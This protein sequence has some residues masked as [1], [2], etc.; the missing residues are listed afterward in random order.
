MEN[1]PSTGKD[2]LKSVK[3]SI[4]PSLLLVLNIFFFGTFSI[5]IANSGEF[6]ISYLQITYLLLLPSLATLIFLQVLYIILRTPVR[7]Y[8]LTLILI[9][10][11]LTYIHSNILLWDYGI[12]DGT[13][14]DFTNDWRAW[15]DGAIWMLLLITGII[16]HQKIIEY[17][18][19]ISGLLI[20]IQFAGASVSY[21]QS[22]DDPLIIKQVQEFPD[23]L[24][25]FSKNGNVIHIILDAFQADIFEEL[26]SE[27]PTYSGL[28]SG[29]TFFRDA[30]TPSA[31]TYLSVSASLSGKVFLNDQ[32][33]SEYLEDTLRGENLYSFFDRHGYEIDV[34]TSL[35]WNKSNELFSSYFRIPAPYLTENQNL[36]TTLMVFDLSIFRQVP[37]FL[38][39][40]VYNSQTWLFSNNFTQNPA[41]RFEHYAHNAFLEDLSFRMSATNRPPVYKF[42]HLV[43]PHAPMVSDKTC[44]FP[45]QVLAY[46]RVNFTQQSLCTMRTVGNFLQNLKKNGIYDSSLILIH[47]DHGGGVPFTMRAHN[48]QITSSKDTKYKLWGA[49]LPLILVKPPNE[50][51]P[52]RISNSQVQLNDIPATV[53]S[54]LGLENNFQG[55]PMY[56]LQEENIVDRQY[57]WSDIHRNDAGAKDFYDYLYTYEIRGSVYDEKSW[58]TG[59]VL[60][61]NVLDER[62]PYKWDSRI[63]FGKKGTSKLV[64]VKGWSISSSDYITWSNDG[65]SILSLDIPKPT[66]DIEL[67]INIKPFIAPG[68][69]DRQR[70]E[71]YIGRRKVGEWFVTKPEFHDETMSI[72]KEYFGNGGLT[73][74]RF[75]FPDAKSPSDL[76]VNKDLRKLGLAFRSILLREN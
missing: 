64:Q 16:Y 65:I 46:N 10:G 73:E 74:V 23:S 11:I 48:G 61:S 36:S 45:G 47:G 68:K 39:P 31:V 14:L 19:P 59:E 13:D 37:H 22:S 12:L 76:G 8:Y 25:Q 62:G 51:G 21:F 63:T 2:I 4:V 71:V 30:T 1:K 69:L 41:L 54:L 72:P 15:S 29:F 70:V 66:T 75:V 35:W 53:S 40:L 38:K 32:L 3:H 33:I 60:S 28:L 26:L 49:P 67:I 7:G 58:S 6:Q 20:L 27:N 17:A 42:I 44:S 50:T 24:G 56:D 55:R 18:L 43:T 57:Y 52:L 34:A 5:Y 9:L